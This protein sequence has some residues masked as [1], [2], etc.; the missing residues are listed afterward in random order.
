MNALRHLGDARRWIGLLA[1]V[2]LLTGGGLVTMTV[3]AM[4]AHAW[5]IE[6]CDVGFDCPGD[7]SGG[8][9]GDTPDCLWES[10]GQ[11]DD[12]GDPDPGDDCSE[13]SCDD[14]QNP[15]AKQCEITID[16][17]GTL[18]CTVKAPAPD[19]PPPDDCLTNGVCPN[20]IGEEP[21]DPDT[22]SPE[23]D[24]PSLFFN[25]DNFTSI[26][27]PEDPF[28]DMDPLYNDGCP[29]MT[30]PPAPA[31]QFGATDVA[32]GDSFISGE[33][34]GDF[35]SGTP[36]GAGTTCDVSPNAWPNIVYGTGN[37]ANLAGEFFGSN[38]T[39]PFENWA[40]TGAVINQIQSQINNAK[41]GRPG[42]LQLRHRTVGGHRRRHRQGRDLSW[43]QRPELRP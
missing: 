33:G 42:Q 43:R 14:D 29:P 38:S 21:I 35:Q 31:T 37:E 22:C 15:P 23:N 3:R 6:E 9:L 10:C 28:P 13:A 20:P 4:P 2:L 17:D 36:S 41:A 30:P 27:L 5:D 8:S 18:V 34:A 40:C 24:G 19:D 11:I 1:A 12:L 7:P 26:S 32:I 16:P 25:Q 39:R